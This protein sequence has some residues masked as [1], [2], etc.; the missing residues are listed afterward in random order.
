MLSLTL[1]TQKKVGTCP[2]PT[3]KLF[4]IFLCVCWKHFFF[5]RKQASVTAS[6]DSALSLTLA[7]E[8][9]LHALLEGLELR[10]ELCKNRIVGVLFD[11][12]VHETHR[13]DKLL[14]MFIL[15]ESEFFGILDH[16]SQ[17][18]MTTEVEVE[19]LG[20]FHFTL[21]FDVGLH[22]IDVVATGF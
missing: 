1:S 8:L 2:V 5:C 18:V 19:N 21:V 12:M 6:R 15:L 22:Y 20:H 7:S 10:A 16:R 9:S 17:I 3:K 13:K 4:L 14:H 11:N